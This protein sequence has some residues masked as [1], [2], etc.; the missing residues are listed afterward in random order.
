VFFHVAGHGPFGEFGGV[1][2]V[3]VLHAAS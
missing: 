3:L 2:F 1:V